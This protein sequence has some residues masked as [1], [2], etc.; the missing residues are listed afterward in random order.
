MS[1]RTPRQILPV[2]AFLTLAAL[3]ACATSPANWGG[4][5]SAGPVVGYVAG[6]GVS[7]GWEAGGGAIGSPNQVSSNGPRAVNML[8][9]GNLGMSWRQAPGGGAYQPT[10]YVAWEP[11]VGPVGATLGYAYS[12]S[13]GSMPLL[14]GW[15]GGAWS[16]S[17]TRCY[18]CTTVS[19]ALGWRWNG[20]SEFYVAPKVG[21]VHGVTFSYGD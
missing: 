12:G 19:L 4:M 18:P 2:A 1:H 14:G 3:P 10:A 13:E 6:R 20:G 17:Y 7:F 5:A 21:F 9:R 15:A 11:A 8:A 16:S